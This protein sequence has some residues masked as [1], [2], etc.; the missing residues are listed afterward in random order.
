[1]R[2]IHSF[3][4]GLLSS[5]SNPLLELPAEWQ[6]VMAR[7]PRETRISMEELIYSIDKY[8]PLTQKME[9]QNISQN[10][11]LWALLQAYKLHNFIP[12]LHI[13]SLS[14]RDI[15][16][17]MARG[18]RTLHLRNWERRKALRKL[19]LIALALHGNHVGIDSSSLELQTSIGLIETTKMIQRNERTTQVFEETVEYWEENHLTL[20]ITFISWYSAQGGFG[21]FHQDARFWNLTGLGED[22]SFWEDKINL[23]QKELGMK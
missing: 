11:L 12:R 18:E 5:D 10:E 13:F 9:E 16:K 4:R 7:K 21:D 8:Y 15:R 6:L 2:V 22:N 3:S 23:Y 1:M 14:D 20:S 17:V 19:T